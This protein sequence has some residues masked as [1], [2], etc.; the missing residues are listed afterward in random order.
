MNH[1]TP[2]QV[3]PDFFYRTAARF[4]D[5]PAVD[6]PPGEGRAGRVV[7][8]YRELGQAAEG[9]AKR[10]S[11]LANG[12]TV[13]ALLLAR[14][15]PDLYAVQLAV[16]SLGAAYTC[17]DPAFPSLQVRDI[18]VDAGAAALITH[19]ASCSQPLEAV[20]AHTRLLW[21]G[22]ALH[23][24]HPPDRHGSSPSRSG[25]S[26]ANGAPIPEE[27]TGWQD[28]NASLSVAPPSRISMLGSGRS[29]AGLPRPSDLA[30]LIYTSG[31]TGKPKGVMIEHGGIANL[32]ASDLEAFQL[33]PQDRVGQSS[34]SAYDSSVEEI[35]LAWASGATL[36]VLD[37]ETV[38]LGPDLVEWLHRERVTVLCPPPTMLRA[39]ACAEPDRAL[40]DLRLL[41][42]GGEM[43]PPDVAA[44]WS[45][46]RRM[47]NGYGPTECSVTSLRAEVTPGA[48]VLIGR[49]IP[50]LRAV[51]L[52]DTFREVAPGQ[53]GELCLA[54]IG[55]ARGYR[56]LPELTAEK[57][58]TLAG[59]G[60]IYRTG[61]LARVDSEGR[62]TCLGRLDDQVKIR[63][64]RIELEAI[65]AKLA[66]CPGV[67]EAA[68][69]V[70]Q[71]RS[72]DY[73]E[74]HVI[75][76]D[77]ANPPDFEGL[78][79]ALGRVLP[80]YM[81]PR[82]FGL[83]HVLPRSIGGKMLRK[84]LP[85]LTGTVD[86]ARRD[87]REPRTPQE[88]LLARAL[89]EVLPA[90]DGVSASDDFFLDWGGD[91][92][93]AALLVS[94]VRHWDA[95]STLSV[96]DVYEGR[97]LER[98]GQRMETGRAAPIIEEREP[99]TLG[100]M[101][102][103]TLV[104]G[105]FVFVLLAVAGAASYLVGWELLPRLHAWM[106]WPGLVLTFAP[107]AIAVLWLATPFFVVFTAAVKRCLIG[108][109]QEGEAPV[110]GSL[111]LRHWIVHQV[112]RSI[113]WNLLAG[114]EFACDAL[115]ALGA[116][117]GE[118]VHIHRGVNLSHGG[119]DLLDLGNDVTLN[120][121]A[122]LRLMELEFRTIRFAP[123][124]VDD[125]AT[126]EL[127][128]GIGP[129]CHLESGATLEAM[130]SLEPGTHVPAGECWRGVPARPVGHSTWRD[131]SKGSAGIRSPRLHGLLT[132][133]AVTGVFGVLALP[134]ELA[135]L[136]WGYEVGLGSATS[137]G[138]LS[139]SWQ[140]FARLAVLEIL[141]VPL[142]WLLAAGLLRLL[143]RVAEGR[144]SRW[145][146]EFIRVW[147][148][149][150]VCK[151]AGDW[152]YGTLFWPWWLRLAGARV[153]R[154]TELS[155]LIDCLPELL[156]IGD[157]AFCADGIYA[158][159]PRISRGEVLLHKVSIGSH[160]FIGNGAVLG[161]GESVPGGILVGICT[162]AG[163]ADLKPGQDWFGDPPFALPRREVH[164]FDQR[165]THHPSLVKVC[166]RVFWECARF[167]LPLPL[168]AAGG[169]WI[170]G[171]AWG[172]SMLPSSVW[173]GL[174]LPWLG[175]AAIAM[176]FLAALALKWVLLGKV[177]P[178]LHPLWSCWASRWDFVCMS[179]SLLAVDLVALVEGTPLLPWLLRSTGMKVGRGVVFG[180]E[181][182][183][184]MADPDMF[185]FE[186]GATVDGLFQ[187]HTFEDRVLKMDPIVIRAGA[188]I[189]RNA[190]LLYG[191]EVG[192]GARVL[193]HSVV[194][195][196]E[197][198]QPGLTYEGFPSHP[199]LMGTPAALLVAVLLGFATRAEG[200][201]DPLQPKVEVEETVYA[202][203]PAQNG[204]G[205]MWCAG[206]TSLVRAG[207][208]VFAAGL[209]TLEG[210]PPL[211]NCRWVFLERDQQG[212]QKRWADP[213]G[214]TR[215]PS[216]LVLVKNRNVLLSANPTLG[217][218]PEPNGGPALP[219]IYR[220]PVEG[221]GEPDSRWQPRWQGQP[222]F[223]EHSYRSFA[224]DPFTDSYILF[225]NIGYTHAEWT[226]VDGS[227]TAQGQ[228]RWPWGAEY[229]TPQPIRLCYPNV[230]IAGR[231]VHFFGVSDV[232]EPYQ[233]WREH[234][235]KLTGQ[236]W[237]YDFRRLFYTWTPD[238]AKRPFA[239]WIEI[240]SRDKTGGFV[241]PC[242][243]WVGARGEIHLLWTERAIDERLRETFF[244][245]AR[246]SHGLYYGVLR[247]GRWVR[248]ATLV[249][250]TEQAPGPVASAA[251][252]HEAPGRR[253]FVAYYWS[254]KAPNGV[255]L[256]ENRVHEIG[257]HAAFS[258]PVT[259]PFAQ[260]F[261]SYFTATPR[262]GSKPSRFL[263]MLGHRAGE[264]STISYARVRLF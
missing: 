5:L 157:Y 102:I 198:L 155:G 78:K 64:Y 256:S 221:S 231:A 216:P 164:G 33:G 261:T 94:R 118:R 225:Q 163:R 92:M 114:T 180:G 17:I 96:R 162:V 223:T 81:I 77:A 229:D 65:E 263:D 210:V 213:V 101:G 257:A 255:A 226:L 236:A 110:Y 88:C 147:I 247:N 167:A 184:D 146:F 44:R 34:S 91:S 156:E 14:T 50:G 240:A 249:E 82:R 127:H 61:D 115:R 138:N 207:D 105:G 241:W 11:P 95:R 74:A 177:R 60:R 10:L 23:P 183:H 246:Q 144:I 27:I 152:L 131:G 182:A 179:W 224:A 176:P 202:F 161:L 104:Q 171:A 109:Y 32:V 181:F 135:L 227:R 86:S 55:L 103:A 29:R 4:P 9:W 243:L 258:P 73:L 214:R 148:K 239:D 245:Q 143:G 97:T 119:W 194:M 120:Q 190:L 145:S 244:P 35:W 54:G 149:T 1:A 191:V 260:P 83:A 80:A 51:L 59:L 58:P 117:V 141:A 21:T 20:P 75:P 43:L 71:D 251:R 42:V 209:E 142:T 79:A 46:G 165:D 151:W 238:A 228:L 234:K 130:A 232:L 235:R 99:A 90:K 193:P 67:M 18:L 189:G 45:R 66:E 166:S 159:G 53:P 195:K 219:E 187:A 41:Y 40:P 168:M 175:L 206:S 160:S 36:V 196:H 197:R 22:G 57:F 199:K 140:S 203:K 178:Q 259:I 253:L 116:R 13:F 70:R 62:F 264:S 172:S 30:Y 170:A 218:P 7:L 124:R 112:A 233:A 49:P 85:V 154:G 100:S 2:P 215:E 158:G 25:A 230:A 211:N 200:A 237:D 204:A 98:I 69:T 28:L 52:D 6:I 8:S 248:R 122:S 128:G 174:W 56:G 185:V 121:D 153:G 208:K 123:V 84:S 26:A 108:R 188:S 47:V 205:P 113:P 134:V 39:M 201:S 106:G 242:D 129:R 15:D 125:A 217:R 3:L 68:C 16:L 38:R 220:F 24:S 107:M 93:T 137:F 192:A 212:W 133:L 139:F 132:L 63:G 87:R 186:D 72:G 37:D 169:V 76:S 89:A 173:F 254:G 250:S 48:P 111:Y 12:E 31:T 222:R 126:V 19:P 262:A 136:V 252:F 150:G